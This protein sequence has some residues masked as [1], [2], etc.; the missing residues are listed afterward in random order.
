MHLHPVDCISPSPNQACLCEGGWA[1][2]ISSQQTI[3]RSSRNSMNVIAYKAPQWVLIAPHRSERLWPGKR[4]PFA[5][6]HLLRNHAAKLLL[7]SHIRNSCPELR[8]IFPRC[9]GFYYFYQDY[10]ENNTPYTI[11][12][13]PIHHQL[14]SIH[15]TPSTIRQ[16]TIPQLTQL[17]VY[18]WQDS[19][20]NT[21]AKF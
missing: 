14:Y 4:L 5:M 21:R 13:T 8:N 9:C 10:L 3:H 18:R 6:M 17:T 20:H 16:D 2:T 12:H 19:A 11:N 7:F 1:Y 15:H